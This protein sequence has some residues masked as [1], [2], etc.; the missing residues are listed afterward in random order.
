MEFGIIIQPRL[1]RDRRADG[2]SSLGIPGRYGSLGCPL[3]TSPSALVLMCSVR[4]PSGGRGPWEY[5][6]MSQECPKQKPK[7]HRKPG[8]PSA[9][10]T[11]VRLNSCGHGARFS[12]LAFLT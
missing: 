9:M 7:A 6:L 10:I 8:L 3:S 5:T 11:I 1:N 2:S 12:L 4:S